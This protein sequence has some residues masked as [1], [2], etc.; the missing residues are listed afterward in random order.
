[1][2]RPARIFFALLALGALSSATALYLETTIPLGAARSPTWSPIGNKVYV[3]ST[4]AGSDYATVVDG[5]TNRIV[6]NIRVASYP[7][8]FAVNTVEGKVYCSSGE[9]NKLNVICAYGDTLIR[10]V[11]LTGRPWAMVYNARRNKLYVLA[12]LDELLYVLD[13]HS[14]SIL[15][16]IHVP[17]PYEMLLQEQTDRLLLPLYTVPDTLMVLDCASDT[18][19][20]RHVLTRGVAGPLCIGLDGMV[21]V[22]C[23]YLL[24]IFS[25]DAES[26]VATMQTPSRSTAISAYFPHQGKLYV[27]N[28]PDSGI[29]V[30][31]CR[32]MAIVDTI[33][34]S[35][36]WP[37]LHDAACD[38]LRDRLYARYADTVLAFDT[39]TDTLVGTVT[40]PHGVDWGLPWNPVDR[41]LYAAGPYLAAVVVLRDT[42]SGV[43][44]SGPGPFSEPSAPSVVRGS[45]RLP[46]ATSGTL[47]DASGRAVLALEPG[48]NDVSRLAPGVYFVLTPHPVPLPQGAREPSSTIA[49][50]VI[51][52]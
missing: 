42:T 14:D 41:R 12:D 46:A 36:S 29:L 15:A 17:N 7:C 27:A 31:D 50:V 1:M 6:A 16:R 24:E 40:L 35:I 22:P 13:A 43:E 11:G 48:T 34:R 18:V 9:R 10:Q 21:F 5:A 45:L 39:R 20:A 47:L 49:K 44:E 38:T 37:S 30:I 3:L 51:A 2:N 32:R 23:R 28:T 4:V 25:A 19:C 26:R 33:A 52:R 8:S